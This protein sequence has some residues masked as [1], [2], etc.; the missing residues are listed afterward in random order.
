MC[1]M[2]IWL[3]LLQQNCSSL[4]GCRPLMLFY[5]QQTIELLSVLL[6][7]CQFYCSVCVCVC[8]C[9]S[10]CVCVCLC[11]C[12]CEHACV[13]VCMCVFVHACV[14]ACVC[15]D[16]VCVNSARSMVTWQTKASPS[17]ITTSWQGEISKLQSL[18]CF[19]L[20]V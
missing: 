12:V 1:G 19:R 7:K 13:C 14:R 11:V 16:S 2:D 4:T 20:Q 9:V 17:A 8:V 6:T 18:E 15:V 10:V 3:N 5:Y